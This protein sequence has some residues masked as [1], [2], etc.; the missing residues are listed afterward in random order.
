MS[1]Q[2]GRWNVSGGPVN[3]DYLE[4]MKTFLAAYGPDGTDSYVNDNIAILCYSLHTTAESRRETLPH[5]TRAGSILTWTGRLDNRGDLVRRFSDLLTANSTDLDI[6]AAAYESEKTASFGILLGDWTLSVWDPLTSSL[7]LAKDSIGTRHLYYSFGDSHVTWSTVLDPLILAENKCFSL[8]EEYIA[9]WF[10]LF[11]AAHVTPY[12]G[13][14][15]VP[16]SSFVLLRPGKREVHKY[17]DFDP[18][19]RIRYQKDE[20]YEEHF[21][22][23]FAEAVRRRLRTDSPAVAELSGGMDSSSIVCMAD[24]LIRSGDTRTPRLDTLSYYIDSEPT[25][26]EKPYFTR[27]EQQRGR[28]GCHIDASKQRFLDF[29]TNGAHFAATPAS[30]TGHDEVARCT[31]ACLRSQQNRVMLS[32]IGGDE[33][34]GGVPTPL[35]ELENLLVTA[36][37]GKLAQQLRAWALT[38]RRPWFH[39]LF[40]TLR[41]FWPPDLPPVPEYKRPL[42][43]LSRSFVRRNRDALLGYERRLKLFG[44]PPVFQENLATLAS[45]RRQLSCEVLPFE[46]PYERRYPYLDRTLLEFIFAIPREQLVRPGQ[47][48]SLMRRAMAGLVPEEILNRKRKAYV[49]RSPALFVSSECSRLVEKTNHMVSCELGI[50]DG[51]SLAAVLNR[52]GAGLPVPA[53]AILR[54]FLIEI[55]LERLLRCNVVAQRM[56]VQ[57]GVEEINAQVHFGILG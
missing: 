11:P 55:W 1:V 13:I 2:F 35:P 49:A 27:I 47:R 24:E 29:G 19:K 52:A 44:P 40:E 41:E 14:S 54:T 51:P 57:K 15:S 39:L 16:A 17:W 22:A 48:R 5:V 50:V 53:V 6:V 56:P 37:L 30:C 31:A 3:R 9:G 42:P 18:F 38:K 26:N 46:P 8:S 36:Q 34:L 7:I 25:W 10:S 12:V 23:L 28:T 32:G 43:W 45:L 21:R 4:S 33:L 20:E